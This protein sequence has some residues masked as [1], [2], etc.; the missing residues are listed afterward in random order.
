MLR[1]VTGWDVTADEL[2]RTAQRIVT[3][4]KMFN[5]DAGWEPDEDTLPKRMLTEALVDDAAARLNEQTL[6]PLIAAY[7]RGRNWSSDGYPTAAELER[8]GISA[9]REVDDHP[10]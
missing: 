9:C 2:R 8:L 7:N 5:I 1:L 10:L 6:T 4:K 3:A